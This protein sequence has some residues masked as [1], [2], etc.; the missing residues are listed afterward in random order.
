MSNIILI[1]DI[2]QY[3][4]FTSCHPNHTKRNVPCFV[5]RKICT[6]VENVATK[7]ERLEDVEDEEYLLNRK[8]SLNENG[9]ETKQIPLSPLRQI[10]ESQENVLMNLIYLCP[11]VLIK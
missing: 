1:V 4:N 10:S 2:H 5:A 8:T 6:V 9:I 7:N 3:L 11:Y